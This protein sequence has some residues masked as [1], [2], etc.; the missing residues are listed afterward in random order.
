MKRILA[1]T[2]PLCILHAALCLADTPASAGTAAPRL[3][4][5]ADGAF[6]FLQ[7]TDI[8]DVGKLPD[9]GAAVLR[10]ALAA[11]KPG[12]VVLT[13]DNV[14]QGANGHAAFEGAMDPVVAIFEEF[15]TPFC[16]TFG[17]HDSERRGKDC[18]SR[19]EQYDW[20]RKR[21]GKLFVDHDVPELTGVGSGAV[22]LFVPG[23]AK[24]SLRIF[25]MD[26]GDNAYGPDG[27]R[28]GYDGCHGD[29]I[30]WYERIAADGVP[31]LW[32]QHII[33]PDVLDTGILRGARDG[34]RRGPELTIRGER[35]RAAVADGVRGKIL[36]PP[37]PPKQSTYHD[38]EHTVEGRTLYD[39]WRRNGHLL[40][41]YFGH[42]H[43]NTFDGVDENGIRLGYTKALTLHSYND[44][45]PG[46]RLFVVHADGSFETEIG[47]EKH[48]FP[49]SEDGTPYR[50]AAPQPPPVAARASAA[51]P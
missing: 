41:A 10:A 6:S 8:Q 27:R 16:V 42:D 51:A 28:N 11:T 7:V 22:E 21:G 47:T 20:F 29:Q 44:D 34:E 3:E 35:V 32:F 36:E 12:L 26:S 46:L 40:G 19:Q 50:P 1:T 43:K 39:A 38:K 49:V 45:D 18:Y 9:R 13:G 5:G 23:A 30:A 2:L 4:F 37:C 24:P 33:V 31:H 48:P 15:G 17:N 14:E 25:V